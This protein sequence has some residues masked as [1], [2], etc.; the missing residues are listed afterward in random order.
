MNLAVLSRHLQPDQAHEAERIK[1]MTDL[2]DG[3]ICIVRRVV[4][5]LRPGIVDDLGLPRALQWQTQEFS[6]YTG[7]QTSLEIGKGSFNLSRDVATAFFRIFQESLTNIARH[8]LATRVVIKLKNV[9]DRVILTVQDNG[10]GII[11]E[12]VANPRSFGIIGMRERALTGNGEFTVHKALAPI[13]F[14]ISPVNSIRSKM[15]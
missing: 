12:Q 10:R 1:A 6:H 5:E 9:G 7:I 15:C 3:T 8:A 13:T 4:T 2:V 14:L 11:S